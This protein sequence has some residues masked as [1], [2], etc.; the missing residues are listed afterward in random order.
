MDTRNRITNVVFDLGGVVLS[1]NQEKCSDETNRFFSFLRE[2]GL[3]PAWVE[4]DRGVISADEISVAL[5]ERSGCPVAM[6][7]AHLDSACRSFAVFPETER[8]I[9]DLS[10]QGYHLYVLS[11][12]PVSFYEHM[13]GFD[14]FRYFDGVV[15]SCEEHLVKPDPAFYTLLLERYGLV[16][17][18]TLFVDDRKPNIDAASALGIHTCHFRNIDAGTKSI[19]EMLGMLDVDR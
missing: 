4:Y 14:V 5:A 11:N 17:G 15:V 2:E 10:A 3:P 8:L 18:E 12:M 19:R 9:H 13:R 16:P 6:A 7:R 1:R